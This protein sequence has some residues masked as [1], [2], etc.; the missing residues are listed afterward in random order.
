MATVFDLLQGAPAS[1]PVPA[2]S[3]FDQGLRSGLTSM[4]GQA[5]ALM[6][7]GAE[8]LGAND[9]AAKGNV[10]SRNLQQQAAAEAPQGEFKDIRSLREGI[11]WTA[12]KLG[13]F[14]PQGAAM[15]GAMLLTRGRVNPMLA[16]AAPM[17][18]M[19]T[20]SQL[21]EQQNDPV[22]A[23]RPASERL[24]L[25]L[26]TGAMSAAA[27]GVVPGM[28][29]GKI[30]APVAGATRAGMGRVMATNMGEA[31]A[32]NAAAEATSDLLHQGAAMKLNPERT[33]DLSRTGEAAA[34]GAV[35]GAPF[36]LAG[37]AGEAL[38]ARSPSAKPDVPGSPEAPAKGLAERFTGLFN[39]EGS[40]DEAT[41][42]AVA[43]DRPIEPMPKGAEPADFIAKNDAT[44]TE[45]AQGKLTGWLEDSGLAPET[46]AKYSELL[47]KVGDQAARAEV[48]SIALARQ[49]KDRAKGLYERMA[50]KAG[51]MKADW[52][53]GRDFIQNGGT[54]SEALASYKGSTKKSEDYSG[55]REI[56]KQELLPALQKHYPEALSDPAT[57]DHLADAVRL[58]VKRLDE[59]KPADKEALS[60]LRQFFGEDAVPTIERV[61]AAV[62]GDKGVSDNVY[63]ALTKHAEHFAGEDALH[64]TVVANLVDKTGVSRGDVREA[65][66]TLKQYTD[67]TM[68]HGKSP[69]RAA[70][71][72]K[73]MRTE[74]E[75]T[76]GKNTDRVLAEFQKDYEA[77]KPKAELQGEKREAGD[78][79]DLESAK[80]SARGETTEHSLEKTDLEQEP[81]RFYGSKEKGLILSHEAHARDYGNQESQASK[82]L[83]RARE[84]NPE[85][86]V[87][88][89]KAKDFA[90]EKGIDE[91]T[92]HEM[93]G[94]KP[95]DYGVVVAEGQRQEGRITQAQAREMLLDSGAYAR[96]KSR[97]DTDVQ[98]ITLDAY[99]ITRD[100]MKR[101]PYIDGETNPR[102]T[103]R[104]FMEGL[105]SALIEFNAK[106]KGEI[107]DDTVIAKR[108]GE[109]MT[110]GDV[111]R[112]SV[113]DPT[114]GKLMRMRDPLTDTRDLASDIV[115]AKRLLDKEPAGSKKAAKLKDLIKEL[116]AQE[117]GRAA[118]EGKDRPTALQS[119][120]DGMGVYEIA[121]DDQ[122]H[123]AAF[124]HEKKGTLTVRHR[125]DE[126]AGPKAGERKPNPAAKEPAEHVAARKM[127]VQDAA[128]DIVQG[129]SAAKAIIDY[130]ASGVPDTN[131]PALP[132]VDSGRTAKG[133]PPSPIKMRA[134]INAINDTKFKNKRELA[135]A[136][137]AIERLNAALGETLKKSPDAAYELQLKKSQ[138]GATG[139]T[140]ASA[141]AQKA[142]G[143]YIHDAFGG[144]VT[145]EW[146]NLMHAGEFAHTPGEAAKPG[147]PAID[148]TYA[149]RLSVHALD[150]MGSAY[151]ESLHAFFQHLREQGNHDV[152]KV[153]YRAADSNAVMKQLRTLLKDSPEALKQI[154]ANKEER[155]A[156]MYQFYARDKLRI[157]PD[158]T[159]VFQRIKAFLLKA[160]G[161]WT[162]DARA[163]HI[164]EYFN[165]GQFASHIGDRN[166]VHRALM[167]P[168]TN[169]ALEYVKSVVEPL[170][171]LEAA[172]LSTG[173]ER[174]RDTDNPALQKIA[175]LIRP[176]IT[177]EAG[178][179]GDVGFMQAAS[180]ERTARLNEWI[181]GMKGVS[182]EDLFA[183]HEA[184]RTGKRPT[185]PNQAKVYDATRKMLD[186]TYDYMKA[187]GV[188]LGDLGYK[189]DYF[190]RI[191]DADF[192]SKHQTEFRTM[193]GKYVATKQF[194]GSVDD[195]M[196]RLM[197]RD[198]SELGVVVDM[199]GMQH[200]KQRVLDFITSDDAAPF[201][202]KNLFQTVNSY[203]VQATRRA[204]WAKRFGDDGSKM[205]K[206]L[207]EARKEHG[208]TDEEINMAQ[209]YIRGIDG[210]LGD[211]L[212]PTARRMFGNMIVYQNLRLLPLAVFSS[213][214]DPMGIMVRG[215]TLG[216]SF[217]AFKRGIAE[218]PRG[219]KKN[220]KDDP[221][222]DLARTIGA[223]DDTTLVHAL[224]SSY[225]QGMV[226]DTA[227]RINDTMF[228]Y[229]LM[230]QF[231]TSMRVSATEAA[232]HFLVKHADGKATQHSGRYLSEL[233][234]KPGDVI[235]QNGRP[236]I[237]AS[238]FVA[239]GMT[240]EQAAVASNRMRGALNRWVDGAVL[241]PNA[242]DKPIW[243][244]DPHYALIAHLKQFVFSFQHTILARVWNE[245]EH[246]NYGPAMA[247]A[248]YVPMMIAADLVKGMIQGGG[249]Q[250]DWK[251]DWGV[252]DYVS[253]GVQR[254]GLYGVSQF[255]AD[256]M[257]GVKQGGV[258]VDRLL[259][260]TVEQGWQA[261]EALGGRKSYKTEAIQALPANALYAN[262]MKA[263]ATDPNF[264]E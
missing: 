237:H 254:A 80:D 122:V 111:K 125:A 106:V 210:T 38:H 73:M 159:N 54:F 68:T 264:S 212:N 33:L 126:P 129:G 223:I 70:Y 15:T 57:V 199:P 35:L 45:W 200:T 31:V 61:A 95:D 190:P 192:I 255:G 64:K 43:G 27:Q 135:N 155:V 225:T 217:K 202:Q 144:R 9:F 131:M 191:W 87:S 195:V 2:P 157:G 109:K 224:G 133:E 204:E 82:L 238:E 235:V 47:S 49:A 173:A 165:E 233:G 261:L 18:P 22:I 74:L 163:I 19:E 138:V 152:M 139:T 189:K 150:P 221:W 260:P 228:K 71:I 17:V 151:H 227:R 226:S 244:N 6:A 145:L 256:F 107:P 65:I 170:K 249:E 193:L 41:A 1:T 230:E 100:T 75:K 8:A 91:V 222:Y 84:Q 213:L 51:D 32:G 154:E 240:P 149:I 236:L 78:D 185:D 110:Y 175:D 250:P 94:G 215:G 46:R 104:A 97:I 197:A 115:D 55:A 28:M 205:R 5:A 128:K 53:A 86:N 252:M 168:G 203:A 12:G 116:E 214:I 21:Q 136:N 196:N 118:N 209:D 181:K 24:P 180:N 117:E 229:N 36:G 56:I 25:A 258:G 207:D 105:A 14:V 59:G 253:S 102:R 7:G 251:K 90:R 4:H 88:F 3:A 160:V 42:R 123:L 101:M 96:S 211:N 48:G 167:E 246:G 76:F 206:L 52:N 176:D 140:P 172:V 239:H 108:N 11:D 247:L 83:A 147:K 103:A 121:K 188:Q 194:N 156:Y 89:M 263:D 184:L 92:L 219:F 132:G 93:T 39:R 77:S 186:D 26:G 30:L 179:G 143:K 262:Y 162:N 34:T 67:G 20:A 220:P 10:L 234:L 60:T 248:G 85:R 148:P 259:G 178:E 171:K 130:Y 231:N 146:A 241:R 201:L 81:P 177:K 119:A 58:Y 216:D 257:Q 62:S 37:A 141:A 158:T 50:E 124:E 120:H 66:R 40:R 137:E 16:A 198:G 113:K 112:M 127:T 134:L 114:T 245:A 44:A 142:V 13:Q 187:A 218:I 79:G 232:T 208:A 169:R 69:E 72:E 153:L 98:G 182:E 166:A 63:A 23:A 183:A 99:K 161:L 164:M 29:G 174:M 242:A 243:M